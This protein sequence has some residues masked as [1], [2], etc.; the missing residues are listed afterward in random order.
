EQIAGGITSEFSLISLLI[1][2]ADC[3][4]WSDPGH[5]ANQREDVGDQEAHRNRIRTMIPNML[6]FR[7]VRIL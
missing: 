4:G 7:Q 2:G 6:T 5:A 3:F 1:G